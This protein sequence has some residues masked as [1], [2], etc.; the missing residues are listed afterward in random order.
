MQRFGVPQGFGAF[1]TPPPSIKPLVSVP[2]LPPS[3]PHIPIG[4]VGRAAGDVVAMKSAICRSAH[5]WDELFPFFICSWIRLSSSS[6]KDCSTGDKVTTGWVGP[7]GTLG[8]GAAPLLGG[9]G[10]AGL[11]AQAVWRQG[12]HCL[13]GMAVVAPTAWSHGNSVTTSLVTW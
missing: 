12:H 13:G 2:R 5:T 3:Q 9:S 1:P 10:T 6:R 7:L 11:V 4:E 8:Q